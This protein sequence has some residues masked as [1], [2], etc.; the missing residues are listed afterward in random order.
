MEMVLVVEYAAY[1]LC[2]NLAHRFQGQ[3]LAQVFNAIAEMEKEH[4]QLAAKGLALC[5]A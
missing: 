1:D 2:R 3:P 4:I 5:E